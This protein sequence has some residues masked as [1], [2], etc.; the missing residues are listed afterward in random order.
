MKTSI[1]NY[2]RKQSFQPNVLSVFINPFFFLR[3][4]LY[5][6]VQRNSRHL[7][8]RLLDFGCGRKPYRNLFA[9]K[10]YV[11]VDIEVSG[12]SHNNS[13]ID[14]YYD[15]KTLPFD[16]E[17]FDS[18]LCSE[19]FEH[20]FNL[21]DIVVEINRVVKK[22]G[23]GLI[24]VPFAWPEHEIPYD[25]AR[26]TSFAMRDILERNG[27]RVLTVEKSGHF[28]ECIIQ[29]FTMYIYTLFHTKNQALNTLFTMIFIS[30]F[31]IAGL[32][33]AAIFPKKQDLFH[34]LVVLVEKK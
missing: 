19:V 14:V 23:R 31:N 3:K 12:H 5:R 4:G 29:L 26:Y 27:F 30:P 34:N 8:G 32:V 33:L 9:V 15:G 18:F 11:G 25:F 16:N 17:T 24:T 6:H 22:G 10:E 28:F 20:L 1:V 21:E 2:L 13:Q 7:E